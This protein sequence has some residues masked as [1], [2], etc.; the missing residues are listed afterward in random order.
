MNVLTPALV[1]PALLY[2][3]GISYFPRE[4]T[5]IKAAEL[6][7][8]NIVTCLAHVQ[9]DGVGGDMGTEA[10]GSPGESSDQ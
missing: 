8:A 10:R 6:N 9:M 1:P 3:T 5:R 2:F 7:P 4:G